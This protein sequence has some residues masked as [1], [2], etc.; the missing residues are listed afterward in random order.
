[1]INA[2]FQYE[3]IKKIK[4]GGFGNIFL[5]RELSTNKEYAIKELNVQYFSVQGFRLLLY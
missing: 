5:A 4:S 1:M 3:F 2:F